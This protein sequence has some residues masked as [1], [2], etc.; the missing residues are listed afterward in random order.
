MLAFPVTKHP[1]IESIVRGMTALGLFFRFFLLW[2]E[3]RRQL[4]D[5][6]IEHVSKGN[7]ASVMGSHIHRKIVSQG[8]SGSWNYAGTFITLKFTT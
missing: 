1:K 8:H 4:F 5:L 3:H 2:N 6:C 7:K